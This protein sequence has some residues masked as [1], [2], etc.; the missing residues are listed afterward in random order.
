MKHRLTEVRRDAIET[1]PL[2]P[3]VDGRGAARARFIRRIVMNAVVFGFSR[4]KAAH[5]A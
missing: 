5:P 3:H 4:P 1:H 2:L